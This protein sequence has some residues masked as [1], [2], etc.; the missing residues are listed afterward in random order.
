MNWLHLGWTRF[1]YT[2][3]SDP[4]SREL[5]YQPT[6]EVRLRNSH[7]GGSDIARLLVDSGAQDTL[8]HADLAIPLGINLATCERREVKGLGGI[9]HGRIHSLEI[10]I[11][12][13]REK[14]IIPEVYFVEGLGTT[15]ILGQLDFFSKYAI[16]FNFRDL[17]FWLKRLPSADDL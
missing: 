1:G 17:L 11:I 4:E 3:F 2:S 7:N 8:I 13:N 14:I 6:I 15:G 5:I 16:E 12:K 9:T 10:E